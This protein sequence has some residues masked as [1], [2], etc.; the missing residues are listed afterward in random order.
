M[1]TVNDSKYKRNERE[2]QPSSDNSKK[3]YEYSVPIYFQFY[4]LT[5][6][7]MICTYRDLVSE[8][9]ISFFDFLS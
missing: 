5:K 1:Q 2:T 3:L 7:A 8:K 9:K 6:R 4:I